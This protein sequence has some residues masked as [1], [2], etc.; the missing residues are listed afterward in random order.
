MVE[1][2]GWLAMMISWLALYLCGKYR[3]GWMLST[4]VW[5]LWFPY[6][7]LIGSLP[8]MMNTTVYAAISLYTWIKWKNVN[9][10]ELRSLSDE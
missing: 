7:L 1:L 3:F 2:L 9:E 6:G 5:L 10:E 8:V 4:L